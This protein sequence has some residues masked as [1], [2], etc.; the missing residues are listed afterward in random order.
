[1]IRTNKTKLTALLLVLVTLFSALFIPVGAVNIS[2]TDTNFG[3]EEIMPM[4]SNNCPVYVPGIGWTG[5]PAWYAAIERV[6]AGGHI[7]RLG[8]K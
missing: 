8:S 7:T 1:M 3:S 4:A 5:S 2:E 6:Q